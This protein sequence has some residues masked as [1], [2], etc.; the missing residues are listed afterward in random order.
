MSV[1]LDLYEYKGV[2]VSKADETVVDWLMS[3]ESTKT[4]V[5]VFLDDCPPEVKAGLKRLGIDIEAD[6]DQVMLV[7]Q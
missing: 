2:V 3:Q 5:V 4:A 1:D 6:D 7:L